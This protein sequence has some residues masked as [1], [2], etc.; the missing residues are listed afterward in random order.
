MNRR[1]A[2]ASWPE[3]KAL[4]DWL[5]KAQGE[6]TF[7]QLASRSAEAG[8]PVSERTLR[9]AFEARLPKE[10]I[11]RAYA[12]AWEKWASAKNTPHE[13]GRAAAGAA[14][15]ARGL[16]LLSLAVS[17]APAGPAPSWP[18]PTYVPGRIGKWTSLTKALKQIHAEA[19]Q[20]SARRLA[21]S[22][23]AA[24]RLSKSTIRNILTGKHPTFEQLA[25]LLEVYGASPKTT[26]G[27]LAAYRR[28]VAVPEPPAVYP[29]DIVERAESDREARLVQKE[30]RLRYRGIGP[31]A[32]LDWYE[33]QVRDAQEAEW[34]RLE[35]WVD[36]LSDEELAALNQQ[37]AAA[38]GRDLRGELIK[39]RDRLG[40]ASGTPPAS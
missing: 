35:R 40:R 19:G 27:M 8:R 20:P 39:A 14:F 9:R 16:E 31:E 12:G 24:G 18:P 32:E 28:I 5:R 15:E 11:V 6:L 36:G 38:S 22:P 37:A 3:R 34:R 4:H 10:E 2:A 25:A 26:S 1:T 29:C 7:V 30:T 23:K 33:E 17:A 13:A 21:A